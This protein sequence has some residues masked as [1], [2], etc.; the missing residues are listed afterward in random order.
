[1]NKKIYIL[2]LLA[3]LFLITTFLVALCLGTSNIGPLKLASLFCNSNTE[4]T[5]YRIIVHVRLPRVL[6]ALLAGCALSVSGAIIQSV[7]N[8]P[9]A[10][11]NIIG[12]NSGA[13]FAMLLAAIL[14][15]FHPALI[16]VFAFIGAMFAALIII[17]I[18]V[19][20]NASRLT[21][22]LIGFAISSILT[23]GINTI[24]IFYPDAYIGAS[25]FII[26]GLSSLTMQ[27]IVFPALY[28]ASGLILAVIFSR[29]LNI[30]SLGTNT[31]KSLGMNVTFT[32]TFMIGI[33]AI[34]AGAAVS[35]AGLL[36][37][38]GLIVPHAVRYLVSNDNKIVIPVSC[39]VG[40]GFLIVCDTVSRILF[41][42][43][44]LPVGILMAFVG[45]P[46]FIFLIMKNRH[47]KY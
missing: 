5:L 24:M 20:T 18:S 14:L 35:F 33:S 27:K 26:G 2:L 25:T 43:Y 31:A 8:N 32:K 39:L 16:P 12:I 4:D 37:F 36:G 7:L 15:P 9:L 44:E 41:A 38:V 17:I 29:D 23:A 42:P 45:A 40:G 6:G 21:I 10:G 34:L 19:S 11:P 46:L 47:A 28:I 3:F 1:M 22:V 13:G 30:L